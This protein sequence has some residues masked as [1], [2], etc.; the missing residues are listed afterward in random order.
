MRN[1]VSVAFLAALAFAPAAFA[2][3]LKKLEQRERDEF[4]ALRV[5][6]TDDEEKEWLKL[7]TSAERDTWLQTHGTPKSYWDR[8]T[9]YTPEQQADILGGEA[10]VGWTQDMLTMAWGE[11]ASNQRIPGGRDAEMSSLLV[12]RFEVDKDG[13]G[14]VWQPHSNVTYK[15][16]DTYRMEIIVDDGRIAEM[17][18]K[19][20]WE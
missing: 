20:G 13:V 16:V 19:D 17:T 5:Y 14:Y 2:D 7:K 10:K 11:P 18:Q 1:L 9:K 8:W 3:K 12:Y 15:A 6:L 4:T